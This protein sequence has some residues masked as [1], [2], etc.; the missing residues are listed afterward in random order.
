[1]KLL[2]VRQRSEGK[3]SGH[4]DR[5]R[6]GRMFPSRR[7]V[8]VLRCMIYG[9]YPPSWRPRRPH[10]TTR[11]ETAAP[12]ITGG[13]QATSGPI[14]QAL[15]SYYAPCV[16]HTTSKGACESGAG[17]AWC[18]RTR[19]DAAASPRVDI[20]VKGLEGPFLIGV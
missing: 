16:M 6:Y 18:G 13:P 14:L 5:R 20:A 4:K 7:S 12:L 3:L 1:M 8:N 9:R 10:E 2:S 11:G 19:D 17:A 15:D